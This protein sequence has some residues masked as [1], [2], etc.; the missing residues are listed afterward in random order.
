[1]LTAIAKKRGWSSYWRWTR[2][3]VAAER[4]PVTNRGNRR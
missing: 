2:V 4:K 1:L 3:A